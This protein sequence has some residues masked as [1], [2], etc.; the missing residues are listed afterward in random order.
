MR[1]KITNSNQS[2]TLD[3]LDD[4]GESSNS[5]SPQSFDAVVMKLVQIGNMYAEMI[6]DNF[7][8]ADA[9]S[10]GAGIDSIKP[11]DV[12]IMGN[13]YSIDIQA[14]DYLSFV[15]AGV[16][17]WASSRNAPYSFKTHGVDPE[18]EMVASIKAYLVREGKMGTDTTKKPASTKEFK[19]RSIGTSVET[20]Q[21]V[22]MA[23]MI[24]RSGIKPRHAIQSAEV[25]MTKMISENFAAALR[26][27]IINNLIS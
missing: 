16:N 10:G 17:G 18:S 4:I 14:A 13:V 27:D 22:T 3:F 12:Q 24:K 26:V 5:F 9:V 19:R 7:N 25:E 8:K 11:L 1:N 6:K 21:A 15:D 20:R 23:Y 2:V